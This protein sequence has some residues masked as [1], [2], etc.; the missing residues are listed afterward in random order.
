MAVAR[1]IPALRRAHWLTDLL[2]AV[3]AAIAAGLTATALDFGG[4]NELDWRAGVF[5]FACA[6]AVAGWMRVVKLRTS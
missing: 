6:L 2:V 1:V 4:W 3:I 5:A